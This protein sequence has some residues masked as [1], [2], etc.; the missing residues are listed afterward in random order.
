MRII[1]KF[2]DCYNSAMGLGQ[3]QS[4]HYLRK[5]VDYYE[6]VHNEFNN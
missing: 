3:D 1:S 4:V 5:Q 6:G 2:S